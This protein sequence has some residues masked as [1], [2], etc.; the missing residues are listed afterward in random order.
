MGEWVRYVG[1]VLFFAFVVSVDYSCCVGLVLDVLQEVSF[2][3][4]LYKKFE[5]L[6]VCFLYLIIGNL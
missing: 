2:L 6:E 5:S 4:K 3:E 1:F